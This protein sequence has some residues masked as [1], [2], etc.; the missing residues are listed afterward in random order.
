M[1]LISA[2]NLLKCHMTYSSP[3]SAIEQLKDWASEQ[4]FSQSDLSTLRAF[5]EVSLEREGNTVD[6]HQ[7]VEDLPEDTEPIEQDQEGLQLTTVNVQMEKGARQGE[8][9]EFD[10]VFQSGN[11]ISIIVPR[12]RKVIADAFEPGLRL[13]K[14][15]CFSPLAVFQATGTI[16]K[17]IPVASGPKRGGHTIDITLDPL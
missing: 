3:D 15:Q 14:L 6:L 11:R 2:K 8:I 13:S 17:K 16:D 7:V 5:L 4:V 1:P 9:V 12:D 10:I